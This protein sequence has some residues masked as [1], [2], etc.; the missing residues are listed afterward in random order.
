LIPSPLNVA[1]LNAM[2]PDWQSVPEIHRRVDCWSRTTVRAALIRLAAAG[3]IEQERRAGDR[4]VIT[5]YVLMFRRGQSL[6]GRSAK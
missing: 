3:Q 6:W 5:G 4:H 2:T 1:V